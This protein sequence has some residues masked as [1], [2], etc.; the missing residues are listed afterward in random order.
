MTTRQDI[1]SEIT[2]IWGYTVDGAPH[3][4]D[5]AHARYMAVLRHLGAR[6]VPIMQEPENNRCVCCG[7]VIVP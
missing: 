7:C 4:T 5:C 2:G 1:S 6:A 3:C